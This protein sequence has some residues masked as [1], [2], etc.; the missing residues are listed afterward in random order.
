M[1]SAAEIRKQIELKRAEYARE[2]LEST[3]RQRK[4]K[5]DLAVA[6][7]EEVR[8]EGLRKQE[9]EQQRAEEEARR[10]EKEHL[11]ALKKKQEEEKRKVS[12]ASRSKRKR[13]EDDDDEESDPNAERSEKDDSDACWNCKS[14]G[15]ECE[16]TG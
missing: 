10:L 12:V 3:N 1:P 7:A 9:E 16:R 13:V 4:L 14:R 11:R 5:A 6:E 2:V 8:L 15:N